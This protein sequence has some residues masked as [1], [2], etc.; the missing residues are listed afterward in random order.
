MEDRKMQAVQTQGYEVG[1]VLYMAMELAN[2]SWKLAFS[3]GEKIRRRSMPARDRARLLEEVQQAKR[4]LAAKADA[5]VV[6]CYEA[7]RDGHWI[8]H[9]L[10]SEGFEVLEIDSSSI[11]MARGRKHVKTDRVDVVKLLDLLLRYAHGYRQAFSVVRVPSR[12]AEAAQR[13][14]REDEHLV[15][16]RARVSNRIQGLLVAQGLME[17]P[18]RGDFEGWL[19]AVRLWDGEALSAPLQDELRRLYRHYTLLNEQLAELAA[20][21]QKELQDTSAV[22]IKRQRLERLKSVGP[23][24]SRVLSA[25]VFSWRRFANAKQLGG[26]SGL[27]PTP[28]R[29]GDSVREQGI[30]KAGNR[31]VR[32]VLIEL[33]WLWLKW[34]PD[35]TLS[36][37]F[38]HRF[39]GGGK[40]QRRVGIV[41]LARKL[42]IALWRYVEW[43][44]VP[45]GA[46]LKAV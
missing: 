13:L 34:Q 26:M 21:Y 4:R 30:S 23:K 33:A 12:A 20:A 8:Y 46:V 28:S 27:A 22:G 9:W 35:S 39:A 15:R 19:A 1:A 17:P 25:E 18:L 32:R 14:H 3:T 2:R 38:Q 5:R 45:Q 6:V 41:A 37:W 11:E 43:G 16:Q 10:R 36:Q 29:S 40:R 24:T 7:G 44:V 31:R 42:L